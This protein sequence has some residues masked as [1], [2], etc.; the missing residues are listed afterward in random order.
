VTPK[1]IA[2]LR[3]EPDP[4]SVAAMEE[5]VTAYGEIIYNPQ[6][7]VS[8]ASPVS[9][10]VWKVEKNIGDAVKK[11]EVL[12]LIEAPDVG[13]LKSDFLQA[14][15][16]LDLKTKTAERKAQLVEVKAVSPAEYALAETEAREA[17]IS[18][19]R[20]QQA[21]A[22]LGM[23]IRLEEV[24]TLSPEEL[25]R[26]VQFLGLPEALLRTLD[27]YTTTSNLFALRSSVNGQVIPR[28]GVPVAGELVDATKTLFVV[29]DTSEMW[30]SLHVPQDDR[31]RVQV[32][33]TV[34]FRADGLSEVVPGKITWK[35][36]E[37]DD[38]RRT[39][40]VRVE[41]P[42][43]K[44]HLLANTFGTGTII[45][46]EEKSAVVVKNG[47]VH[48]DGNCNIVFVRDKDFFTNG[49]PKLFHVRSIRLGARNDEYTEVIAGV[50]PGEV[51]IVNGSEALR[52][53]LLKSTL[54]AG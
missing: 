49:A 1:A 15:A 24:K 47:A 12:A 37:V 33:H 20:A 35:S 25:G 48:S 53:Q 38:V 51:V 10:K 4:V 36:P 43:P 22:N 21:L 41:L 26:R 19:V 17:H 40:Q 28:K 5:T 39:M 46:R 54:G 45:L 27:P 3:L 9:G 34:R 8:L 31:Q 11:D 52:T 18:A 7:I 6:R 23:S 14:V 32:G 16:Q 2:K 44:G 30:L 50:L 42:N 29:A 13:K